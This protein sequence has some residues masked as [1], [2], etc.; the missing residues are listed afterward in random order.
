MQD[1][2][3]TMLNGKI[4]LGDVITTFNGEQVSDPRDLARKA[5]AAPI[6]SDA[7]LAHLIQRM[8]GIRW[9]M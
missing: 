4:K 8:A 6:G 9:R 1:D 7:V 5:A 2:G 3:D